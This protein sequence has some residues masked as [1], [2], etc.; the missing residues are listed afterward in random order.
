MRRGLTEP[1]SAACGDLIRASAST[2]SL[3]RWRQL[4]EENARLRALLGLD[5]RATGGHQSAWAPTLFAH[6]EP[7]RG[8]RFDGDRWARSWSCSGRCSAPAPTCT[9]PGGRTRRPAVG[10]VAGNPGGWSRQRRSATSTCPCP[11]RPWPLISVARRRSASTRSCRG[12][13]CTLLACDFD[14]GTW[15][16]DALAYLD[17]C[18]ANGV[19]AVLERSRSGNGGHVWVFFAAPVPASEARALGAALLRQAMAAR[20]ELDLSSYDRFFPSQDFLPK[21]GFGNLIALPLQG[22]RARAGTTVFLD[23]TTL[24]PYRDQWAFLS[25]VARLAPDAVSELARRFVR[26]MPVRAAASRSSPARAD[27]LPRRSS[28]ARSRAAC[29]SNEPASHRRSS[30]R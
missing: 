12:D 16:L 30:P 7:D 21:A 15:L 13:T 17:A 10:L 2:I 8:P 3:A 20:A 18:H 9:P 26:S 5:T 6:P 28:G 27:L 19:P 29:R 11:T 23:P 1:S 24:E 4:R 25:T 14:K 22:E